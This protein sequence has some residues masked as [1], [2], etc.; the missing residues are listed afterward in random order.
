MGA[1]VGRPR[2]PI[3]KPYLDIYESVDRPVGSYVV[4]DRDRTLIED[5]GYTWRVD[6]LVWR[7]G[8]LDLLR[9][10]T[11]QHVPVFLATNQSG[12]ARGYFRRSDLNAFHDTLVAEA[13]RHGARITAICTCPH[14][15]DSCECRKPKPGMLNCLAYEFGLDPRMGLAVGD[16]HKDMEAAMQAGLSF[17][18]AS[19]PVHEWSSSVRAWSCV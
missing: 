7:S 14:V 2:E 3:L 13:R 4:F 11:D 1:E 8:A 19:G 18:D 10:L 6:D 5:D 9:D 17:V 16:S 15:G 12:L